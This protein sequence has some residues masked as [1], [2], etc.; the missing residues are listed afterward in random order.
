MGTQTTKEQD[1]KYKAAEAAR[2][3]K[4]A[5]VL[6]SDRASEQTQLDAVLE[7]LA[8]LEKMCAHAEPDTYAERKQRREAELAGLKEALT[9]LEGES[10]L[11]QQGAHRVF[12]G[13]RL[14]VA[15]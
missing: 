10:V 12:R 9:I 13:A 6:T 1:A 14:H 2:L 15:K 8:K 7:Y 3:D 11:L 4:S 5:G